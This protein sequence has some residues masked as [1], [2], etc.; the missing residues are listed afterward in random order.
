MLKIVPKEI[1]KYFITVFCMGIVAFFLGLLFDNKYIYIAYASG[2]FVSFFM[3]LYLLY[4]T[5]KVVYEYK[6]VSLMSLRYITSFIIY[7]ISIYLISLVIEDKYAILANALGLIS[8]RL[9]IY[10]YLLV[11][12]I[13]RK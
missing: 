7:A 2:V 1:R 6:G 5:Y 8:F 10:F 11:N 9:V 12:K 4:I 3:N 13:I